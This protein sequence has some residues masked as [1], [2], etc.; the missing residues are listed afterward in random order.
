MV[1]VDRVPERFN[2]YHVVIDNYAAGYNATEHLIKQGCRRIAHFTGAQHI[3][4]YQ[5]RRMGYLDALRDYAITPEEEL[6]FVMN[7]LS[8]KEGKKATKLLLKSSNPPDGIFCANDTTA[9][10]AILCAKKMEINVPKELAIIGFN[11]DPISRIIEPS[12]STVSHPALKMGEISAKRILEH[13]H[14][15]ADAYMSEITILNTEIIVRNSSNR[16]L[17]PK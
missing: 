15:K 7:T 14:S 17:V 2:S 8:A 3:N 1:F 13:D 16:N 12:L 10:S 5:K 11:D 6:V 4:V 9:I